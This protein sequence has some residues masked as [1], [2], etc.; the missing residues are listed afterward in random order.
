MPGRS[1]AAPLSMQQEERISC[2]WDPTG[3]SRR[4]LSFTLREHR[5]LLLS[6]S[7]NS[8]HT[9][10]GCVSNTSCQ[11][12]LQEV[13]FPGQA[14]AWGFGV[15]ILEA[16]CALA[17]RPSRLLWCPDHCWL[18]HLAALAWPG[19]RVLCCLWCREWPLRKNNCSTGQEQMEPSPPDGKHTNCLSRT[20]NQ[21]L[22]GVGGVGRS[23]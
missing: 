20:A 19:L 6:H 7:R 17:L 16:T 23:T 14:G 12:L 13:A 8:H 11:L 2:H 5:A 22:F 21:R 9:S 4:L 10:A 1:S 15:F 3:H 18:S